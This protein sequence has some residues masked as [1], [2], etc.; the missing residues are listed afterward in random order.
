MQRSRV[1][2]VL[3]LLKALLSALVVAAVAF[4]RGLHGA[5]SPDCRRVQRSFTSWVGTPTGPPKPPKLKIL[6]PSTPWQ[7]AV[8]ARPTGRM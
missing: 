2:L 1:V 7:V 5:P 8:T 4:A 3:A 6:P